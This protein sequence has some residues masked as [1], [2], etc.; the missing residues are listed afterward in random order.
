MQSC[1]LSSGTY[2]IRVVEV[3]R[4]RNLNKLSFVIAIKVKYTSN[5]VPRIINV[6]RIAPNVAVLGDVWIVWLQG[7]TDGQTGNIRMMSVI[8][9]T[10]S[11][12]LCPPAV[13]E[14]QLPGR[15]TWGISVKCI[16]DY[17]LCHSHIS[18]VCVP[19]SHVWLG[20]ISRH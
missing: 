18:S 1:T 19:D 13:L 20:I 9:M 2:H 16:G 7:Q 17:D 4:P 14:A 12:S 3:A 6:S 11:T 8:D 5:T 10:A 15:P